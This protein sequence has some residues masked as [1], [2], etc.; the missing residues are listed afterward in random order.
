MND[1]STGANNEMDLVVAHRSQYVGLSNRAIASQFVGAQIPVINRKLGV[2]VSLSNDFIGYQR[3]S[4][5]KASGAYHIDLKGNTLSFGIG[6]GA[7]QM[8]LNGARLRAAGGDYE[9]Q[10]VIH[11]DELLPEVGVGSAAFTSS[12]GVQ[13]RTK[14]FTVGIGAQNINS[15]KIQF[16]S[17]SNGTFTELSR[18]I[19]LHS[20][21]VLDVGSVELHPSFF[22][23]TDFIKHQMQTD[24]SVAFKNIIL[25]AAFRGYSGFNNDAVIGHF[26]FRI[27]EKFRVSYSYDYNV[28]GLSPANSGTHE[29]SFRFTNL[30]KF[31]EKSVGNILYT[32]RFL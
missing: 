31:K 7:V 15:P 11:N 3:F 32:P 1:A 2:G 21:Y 17:V 10:Q 13:F 24:L 27:K 19:N 16:S 5:M 14:K 29:I 4:L 6:L 28:S 20:T 22:Y 9:N 26:G 18:T 30:K 25:G 8:N 23:K 12:A